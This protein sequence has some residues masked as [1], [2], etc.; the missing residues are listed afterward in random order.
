MPLIFEMV[1][2]TGR[3]VHWPHKVRYTGR[4]AELEKAMA[5]SD[6]DTWIEQHL[7]HDRCLY[8]GH[9]WFFK[10]RQDAEYFLANWP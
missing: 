6:I 1:S 5:E 2:Y 3:Q 7:G 4:K 8:D 9:A 10:T